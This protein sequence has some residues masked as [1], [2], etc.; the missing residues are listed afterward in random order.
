MS[1]KIEFEGSPTFGVEGPRPLFNVPEG[2]E[3]DMD[4]N[5]KITLEPIE[6]KL[7]PCPFCGLSEALSVSLTGPNGSYFVLCDSCFTNGPYASTTHEAIEWW[8]RR[9]GE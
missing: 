5:Y 7:K 1:K 6:P 4:R 3:V 2:I 8:N 9:K